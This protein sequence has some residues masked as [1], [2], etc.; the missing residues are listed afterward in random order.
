M[1]TSAVA[2]FPVITSVSPRER[3]AAGRSADSA[4][5]R[6]LLA[7]VMLLAWFALLLQLWLSAQLA[8]ANG[9]SALAGIAQALCYFT[10][11]TNLA[12]AVVTTEQLRGAPWLQQR[13]GL[14]A[15]AA[16]YILVVGAIY[17]LLLRATWAPTGLQRLADVLL[18]DVVP[19]GYVLWWLACAPKV[20]LR[21]KTALWW[22]SYP[23]AYF[24]FSLLFGALSGRYLYPFADLS[25]L[26]APVVVRNAALLL[27]FFYLL[28]LAAIALARR[29]VRRPWPAPPETA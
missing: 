14:L 8:R 4:A 21:W 20:A 5:G 16:V 13:R 18:H 27:A 2:T 3:R 6:T 28:G 15:A 25:R 9:G 29:S 19:L 24:G 1:Y 10:V 17:L 11:L 12:V 23:L 22:L 7:V 26:A